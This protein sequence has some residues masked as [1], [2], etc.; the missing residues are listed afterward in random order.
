MDSRPAAATTDSAIRR[1]SFSLTLPANATPVSA[2]IAIPGMEIKT[3]R[4]V[5]AVITPS[6]PRDT[7][8][9]TLNTEK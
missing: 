9:T 2:P 7:T 4:N 1:N 3:N 8:M 6:T 5:D